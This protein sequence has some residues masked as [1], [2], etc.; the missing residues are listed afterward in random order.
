MY[1]DSLPLIVE[2]SLRKDFTK[3]APCMVKTH[4]LHNHNNINKNGK[5]H[6]AAKQQSGKTKGSGR[7][8]VGCETYGVSR[9]GGSRGSEGSEGNNEGDKEEEE[10]EEV[11]ILREHKGV[12]EVFDYE[13]DLILVFGTSLQ[14]A[15]VC[16]IPNMAPP[17]CTRVLV[18]KSLSDVLQ[19]NAWTN[20]TPDNIHYNG[21]Y[22]TDNRG[23]GLYSNGC[24]GGGGICTYTKLAG[25]KV[26][27]KSLWGGGSGI[28]N[29]NNEIISSNPP[30]IA[31]GLGG[32]KQEQRK[33]K[34]QQQQL[35]VSDTCDS[36]VKRFF[37]SPVAH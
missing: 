14:V 34:N 21:K 3:L 36:F 18:N 27:L 20:N 28:R 13:V 4:E 24:M 17:N 33:T 11:I 9:N 12:R 16:A 30:E 22:D 37:E 10:E 19:G 15:P 1:D 26:T 6:F 25:R 29:K 32:Y 8:T 23:G 35:L 7:T 2:N 31:V 5:D